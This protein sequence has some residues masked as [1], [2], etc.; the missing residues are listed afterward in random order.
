MEQQL[1]MPMVDYLIDLGYK[2]IYD[3]DPMNLQVKLCSKQFPEKYNPKNK[4][5]MNDFKNKYTNEINTKEWKDALEQW[6]KENWACGCQWR[7][8][9]NSL[10]FESI[11][12]QEELNT[13]WHISGL[14]PEL[15][16]YRETFGVPTRQVWSAS[17]YR[18]KEESIMA[19]RYDL[20][21]NDDYELD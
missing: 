21:T 9:L 17:E 12:T 10:Q 8:Y 15:E 11:G 2:I 1:T 19:F 4:P 16:Q 5:Q 6:K 18:K 3:V 7:N 14:N 20:E 13:I